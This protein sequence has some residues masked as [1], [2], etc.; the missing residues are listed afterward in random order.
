MPALSCQHAVWPGEGYPRG[1]ANQQLKMK[2]AQDVTPEGQY[3]RALQE[4]DLREI[5]ASDVRSVFHLKYR[6]RLDEILSA[7]RHS[8]APGAHIAEIGCSQANA[9]LLLAEAGYLTVGLDLR[10]EA[11]QYARRKHQRG[12]FAP[13][14]GSAAALPLTKGSFDAAILGELLEHCPDPLAAIRQVSAILR[15]GGILIVTTPNGRYWG[16]P[17][18]LYDPNVPLRQPH[19]QLGPPGEDHPF[20]FTSESLIPLLTASGLQII[21]S[22][23]TG[24]VLYGN[25]AGMVKNLLPVSVLKWLSSL[26][27]KLPGLNRILSYTLVVVCRKT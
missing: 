12:S 1:Q 11:L 24:S 20:V 23:Y 13:L 8:C 22:G 17:D 27:N 4:F 6:S 18:P 14:V 7:V 2:S 26:V 10:R 25:T 5:D 9:S 3:E 16:N 21:R 19:R 15:P